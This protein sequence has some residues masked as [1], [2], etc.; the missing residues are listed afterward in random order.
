MRIVYAVLS[1]FFL[2]FAVVQFNDPDPA[3]WM[4]LYGGVAVLAA[5]VA[6]DREGHPLFRP[7]VWLWLLWAVFWAGILTPEVAD[8]VQRGAPNIAGTMKAETPYVEA[9]REFFGLLLTVAACAL[10][11]RRKW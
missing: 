7:A 11:L 1:L 4:V 2:V 9:T 3:A 6:L 5:L 8:W 10:L